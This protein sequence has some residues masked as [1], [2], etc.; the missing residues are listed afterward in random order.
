MEVEG[1]YANGPGEKLKVFSMFD[2]TGNL[3]GSR[4]EMSVQYRGRA[5]NPDNAIAFKVVLGG[6]TP[7]ETNFAQRT[8]GVRNLNA[9]QTYFWQASWTPTSFRVL[10]RDGGATGSV[11][12]DLSLPAPAASPYAPSPHYAYL[13]AT[14]G[15]FGLDTGSWPMAVY[16]NVWL[17]DKPR[18]ASLGR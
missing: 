8:A 6:G 17:S 13:G 18:P 11:I 16:R 10:V 7:V 12:Y 3:T 15:T 2:G 5:G 4:Y 1:L 14:S 9:G